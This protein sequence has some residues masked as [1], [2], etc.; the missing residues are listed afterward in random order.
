MP[1]FGNGARGKDSRSHPA[2]VG[3]LD[4]R[5]Y[6]AHLTSFLGRLHPFPDSRTY[7][8]PPT[9][10]GAR[11]ANGSSPPAGAGVADERVA[12]TRQVKEASDIVAVLGS[13]LTLHPA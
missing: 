13:Y 3:R 1:S 9:D 2:S 12:L 4:L 7:D 11:R 10:G 8:R 5:P 6:G